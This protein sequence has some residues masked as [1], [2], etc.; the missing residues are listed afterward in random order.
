MDFHITLAGA[1]VGF[2]IGL[3]GMGGGAL[4]TPILVIF[5][6]IQPLAAVSSDLV[7]SVIVKPFGA[8]VHAKRGTVH[9]RVA[10]WLCLGSVPAAFCGVLILRSLGNDTVLQDRIKLGLGIALLLAAGGI[11]ARA[12]V[13]ARRRVDDAPGPVHARPLAT[14]IV[15]VLGG[16]V[17][18][19]TS[20]GSG[21]LI[22]VTLMF[23]YP[24]L[25]TAQLVGT[26]L[27]QAI[28]LVGSAAIGHLIFGDFKLGLTSSLLLGAIPAVYL[29]ARLSASAHTGLIRRALVVVLL[30]SSAK[31]LNASNTLLLEV[32]IAATVI[33][34]LTWAVP[35]YRARRAVA[36]EQPSE[37]TRVAD[38]A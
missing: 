16:L 22:I 9:R 19:M 25:T 10:A 38:A 21:S 17:V 27:V 34:T 31:L 32:T 5:F 1:I 6:N 36:L 37:A 3:T 26:D 33:A 28:P 30:A 18:G 2:V 29:G 13:S 12:I 7:A 35:A 4:M 11:V 20:V 15:G 23:L 24:R 8:A 14:V